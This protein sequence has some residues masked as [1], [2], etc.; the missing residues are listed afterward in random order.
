MMTVKQ[1]V[2]IKGTKEGLVFYLDDTC[3]LEDLFTELKEKVENSHQQILTGP[4]I[5][6]TVNLGMRYLNA[7]QE[8]RLVAILRTRGNLVIK[9]IETG[10]IT[11]EDALRE[12]LSAQ[13]RIY[14]K[15]VRSGQIISQHGDLLVLGD[16]N[17]GALILCTGNIFVLGSLMGTAHAGCEGNAECIIAAYTMV[18]T[19]LRIAGVISRPPD[20]WETASTEMEF[21]YLLDGRMAIEKLTQLHKIRPQIGDITL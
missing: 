3:S 9:A 6:I 12:K 17:P 10:V 11:K 4:V 15:T 13:I 14:S 19:Q 16:V 21:A 2:M 1:N 20:E 5:R 8:E 7:E 18:P